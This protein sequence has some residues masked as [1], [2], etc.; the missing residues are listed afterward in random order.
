MYIYQKSIQYLI[1]FSN[2]FLALC[3]HILK[4]FTPTITNTYSY[5]QTLYLLPNQ[6][7]YFNEGTLYP[8][9]PL[10]NITPIN[11]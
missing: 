11:R 2:N 9:Y 6:N 5:F 4:T 3:M 7:T 8:F 10:K 1:L